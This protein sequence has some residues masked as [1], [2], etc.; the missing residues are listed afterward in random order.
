MRRWP[1]PSMG[2][3]VGQMLGPVSRQGLSE[4]VI[5]TD[6]GYAACG[7]DRLWPTSFS[8]FVTRGRYRTKAAD[9]LRG[10]IGS[11]QT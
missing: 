3:L 2:M 8:G 7:T 10:L 9:A 6:P 4:P 5:C 1:Q 11:Q